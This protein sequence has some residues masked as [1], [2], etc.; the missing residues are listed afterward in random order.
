[1]LQCCEGEE[2]L[3]RL[4]FFGGLISFLSLLFM[5]LVSIFHT[6]TQGFFSYIAAL[7]Y[8]LLKS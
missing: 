2:N 3:M 7:S 1:M 6:R 4:R 8:R 5:L